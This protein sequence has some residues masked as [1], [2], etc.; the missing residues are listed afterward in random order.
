MSSLCWSATAT[1]FDSIRNAVSLLPVSIEYRAKFCLSSRPAIT[2]RLPIALSCEAQSRAAS[3]TFPARCSSDA[4]VRVFASAIDS[5]L[6]SF[7]SARIISC[8][9]RAKSSR[10]TF[11][12]ALAIR[13]S[14]SVSAARFFHWRGLNGSSASSLADDSCGRGPSASVVTAL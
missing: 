9:S 1:L 14:A 7:G 13:I 6:S 11:R 5:N 2:E 4:S 3:T 12:K 8:S 10:L